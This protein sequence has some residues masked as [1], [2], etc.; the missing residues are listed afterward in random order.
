[1]AYGH[2]QTWLEASKAFAQMLR[3]IPDQHCVHVWP[4][5]F[6]LLGEDEGVCRQQHA[7]WIRDMI[8]QF[9]HCG[10]LEVAEKGT[11]YTDSKFLVFHRAVDFY[12]YTGAEATDRPSHH[13]P[14]AA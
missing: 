4:L 11:T 13:L 8:K 7:N 12:D 6:V 2:F 14:T 10:V 3:A 1:M 9:E 5:V